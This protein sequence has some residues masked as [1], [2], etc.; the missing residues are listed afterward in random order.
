MAVHCE[1]YDVL[2]QSLKECCADRP[3]R[4]IGI[5]GA[6]GTGKSPLADQLAIG[7]AGRVIHFDDHHPGTGSPYVEKL[8]VPAVLKAI[9]NIP[10]SEPILIDAI[11][12][13]DVL[14]RLGYT[15]DC[16]VYVFPQDPCAIENDWFEEEIQ[17]DQVL[18][19][20]GTSRGASLDREIATYT[21]IRRPQDCADFTF[22]WPAQTD[23]QG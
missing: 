13:L 8:D 14:D 23:G 21:K 3:C 5:D 2:F 19:A 11:C 15:A 10:E 4:L 16:L 6:M 7:L 12:C 1:G 22:R 17:L 20:L 9:S 18:C